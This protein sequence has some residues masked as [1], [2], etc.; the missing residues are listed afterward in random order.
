MIFTIPGEPVGKARPRVVRQGNRV[1]A[2]T[3]KKT[4]EYEQ[5]VRDAYLAAGGTH[6]GKQPIVMNIIAEFGI[7]KS[8]SKATRQKMLNAEILPI[9]PSDADNLGKIIL[10][11][12]QGVAYDNDSCV[13]QLS[14]LKIYSEEPKVIVEVTEFGGETT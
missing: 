13:V 7:P 3:P 5:R 2:Y 4:A 10:D 9:K 11:G 12:I 8:A 6:H 1:H 14:V